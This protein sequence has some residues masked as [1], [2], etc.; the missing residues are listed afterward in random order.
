LYREIDENI[1]LFDTGKIAHKS[2]QEI[3]DHFPFVEL[4][5]FVVMPNHL[6]G[7]IVID[8]PKKWEQDKF[9]K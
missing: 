6:H 2:W 1:H 4:G 8:N 9:F 5:A 7:I 3:P